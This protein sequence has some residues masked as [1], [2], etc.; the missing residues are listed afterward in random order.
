MTA[1]MDGCP[2]NH[3]GEWSVN[4]GILYASDV[5]RIA[6]VLHISYV[7]WTQTQQFPLLSPA[8]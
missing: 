4:A 5:L 6:H 2:T 8:Q 7:D 3:I 1:E